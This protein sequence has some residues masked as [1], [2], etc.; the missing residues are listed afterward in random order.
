MSADNVSPIRVADW[1]T[2]DSRY[3]EDEFYCASRS[4]D[5]QSM[6]VSV[7]V[8]AHV[9][10][11]ISHLVQKGEFPYRT[12]EDFWR[13]A[14]HHRLHKLNELGELG[15]EASRRIALWRRQ[16]ELDRHEAEVEATERLIADTGRMLKKARAEG[17]VVLESLIVQ[18]ANEAAKDLHEPWKGRLAGAVEEVVG[19]G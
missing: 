6:T 5:G 11:M 7:S 15:P 19:D 9:G 16:E 2:E 18:Q 17:D 13:D 3:S 14:A 12:R 4:A 1:G 10:S 8:P